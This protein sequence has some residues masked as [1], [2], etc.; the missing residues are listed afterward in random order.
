M[1]K[2][3][4]YDDALLELNK[5]LH[6][7]EKAKN[8]IFLPSDD[9]IAYLDSAEL[10]TEWVAL[11]AELTWEKAELADLANDKVVSDEFFLKCL[12]LLLLEIKSEPSIFKPKQ[13][14]RVVQI[15]SWFPHEGIPQKSLALASELQLLPE[16]T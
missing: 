16:A 1:K 14:D 13:R 11:L 6:S 5:F 4:F 10:Q 9:F 7:Q 3:G 12:H 8:F 15:L 2:G